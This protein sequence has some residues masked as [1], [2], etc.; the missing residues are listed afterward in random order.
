MEADALDVQEQQIVDEEA[1]AEE[2][3]D[4]VARARDSVWGH[5]VTHPKGVLLRARSRPPPRRRS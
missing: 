4:A 3:L 2:L 5:R 1:A